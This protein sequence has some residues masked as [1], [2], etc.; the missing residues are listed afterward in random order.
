MS[1]KLK[2]YRLV[3]AIG[4]GF[5]L[6]LLIGYAF[7]VG[8]PSAEQR[9]PYIA[10]FK[11]IGDIF[12]R[13]VK[14]IIPVII[15]FTIA[16]SVASIKNA[17][18]LGKILV[19]IIVI[20]A[21]TSI[22]GATWGLIGGLVFKPGAGVNLTPPS[23]YTA[24][25]PMKG[26]EILLSFFKSDF[27]QLLTAKGAMTMIIF[28]I[29][30]GVAVTLVGDR[31]RKIAD[32][33][34]LISDVL[35]R[36]V[37]II[38]WYAP[39]ALFGYGVWLM[40]TYGPKILGAYGKFLGA[41]YLMT[42]I[43]LFLVYSIVVL[44]GGLSPLKFFK[45]Q[46]EP[47][48]IAYSTRSSAVN[49]PFNMAAAK[50]MGVPDEVFGITVPIGATVNMDGTALYQV[51]SALF[52]A[53]LFNIH[54]GPGAYALLIFSALVGSMAT[55]AIPSGGTIML[56]FVLSVVGL[57]LEGIAIM[58]AVDPIADALRTAVNAS[59]DNACSVLI[60]RLIGMKLRKGPVTEEAEL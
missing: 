27:S 41:D 23:G 24:P 17:K 38:M 48:I 42:F 58:M 2:R 31:G 33:L 34:K 3:I 20:Y 30:F 35:I 29:L 5:L 51:M 13:L 43:H 39:I 28:A 47:F 53:Q 40:A 52:I 15:F 26:P 50:R 7:M 37:R 25:T 9:A 49:L 19:W 1:E 57:P 11:A 44:L 59:G 56:A 32:G 12:V 36:I 10:W 22:I 54:L 6:G 14:M 21:I 18:V 8:I 46:A 45:E 55:A 4:I 16:S 60:T